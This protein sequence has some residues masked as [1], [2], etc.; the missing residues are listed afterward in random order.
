MRDCNDKLL[1]FLIL[2]CHTANINEINNKVKKSE[3]VS[4]AKIVE[5]FSL[6]KLRHEWQIRDC[7][8]F[9]NK[10]KDIVLGFDWMLNK[11]DQIK[12]N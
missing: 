8:I 6:Y 1:P 12:I 9:E 4:C 3:G 7:Q 2:S 5:T 10:M 11:I